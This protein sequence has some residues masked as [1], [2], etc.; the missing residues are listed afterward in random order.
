MDDFNPGY[1]ERYSSQTFKRLLSNKKDY[2]NMEDAQNALDRANDNYD[3]NSS[4]RGK[5]N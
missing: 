2:V 1:W 3:S 5:Y 4:I